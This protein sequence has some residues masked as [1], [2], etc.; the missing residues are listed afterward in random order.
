MSA[1]NLFVGLT[2]KEKEE[3]RHSLKYSPLVQKLREVLE[4]EIKRLEMPSKDA[5]ENAAWAYRQA[6]DNGE[7]RALS[8]VLKLLTP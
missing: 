1:V 8:K 4:A 5:Y 3:F 2:E 7:R 6:D